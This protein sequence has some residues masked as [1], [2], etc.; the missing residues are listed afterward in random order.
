VHF[1]GLYYTII[2][3]NVFR[4][5]VTSPFTVRTG[6]RLQLQNYSHT[7]TIIILHPV[8]FVQSMFGIVFS[9][10][11]NNINDFTFLYLSP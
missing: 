2:H 11:Y 10:Q 6:T 4:S 1:I 5:A 7:W 8:V 3:C 9:E